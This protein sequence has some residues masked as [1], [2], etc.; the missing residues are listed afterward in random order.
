MGTQPI[1]HML[2]AFSHT[3][4]IVRHAITQFTHANAVI[5][6]TGCSGKPGTHPSRRPFQSMTNLPNSSSRQLTVLPYLCDTKSVGLW[7]SGHVLCGFPWMTGTLNLYLIWT[8]FSFLFSSINCR[9]LLC[10][11]SPFYFSALKINSNWKVQILSWWLIL[12][13]NLRWEWLWII[14]INDLCFLKN[15]N[16]CLQL[17]AHAFTLR[18]IWLF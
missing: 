14:A 4:L 10:S 16:Y 11:H 1:V 5:V 9:L 3:N 7:D 8:C 15:G 13:Y 18:C 17:C 6:C 2:I 12:I